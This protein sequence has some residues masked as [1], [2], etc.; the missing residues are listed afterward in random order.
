MRYVDYDE[1]MATLSPAAAVQ[2]VRDALLSGFDPATDPQRQKVAFPH[3]EMHLLPSALD[4]AVGV[5]VLGIQ[6]PGSTVDVPLVQGSYLLM[7]GETLTP[8][9]L[10]DAAA[11][12]T[13]RTP[14]VAVAGVL[15][16]LDDPVNA[17]IFG[18]GAQGHGHAR[19]LEDLLDVSCTFVSRT[20]PDGFAYPWVEA[21]SAAADEAVAGADLVVTATSSPSPILS[22]EHL[23]DD[24]I[25]LAVGAHTTDTRELATDVLDG[26]Q[27]I[28]EDL[29]AAKREAG[30]VAI[31]VEEG[32]LAWDDVVSMADVVR[33]N[34]SL[35]TSRRIVFKTV[36]MPWE[37]LAVARALAAAAS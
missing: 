9:W 1:A 21:G 23:R 27:V 6:P 11:L 3:G 30:D 2:A 26:A 32:A 15:S 14:A 37:D 4:G 31:A 25:V 19:T 18:T 7:G 17:V 29:E 8:E 35:N 5:K 10:I 13:L 36:G 34:V 28:V 12:T 33:G 20:R 22:A 16:L 24:A